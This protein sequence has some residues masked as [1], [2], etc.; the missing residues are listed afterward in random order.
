M[1]CITVIQ[2]EQETV[3]LKL[4]PL[5]KLNSRYARTVSGGGGQHGMRHYHRISGG[6]RKLG[7]LSG[8]SIAGSRPT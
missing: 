3:A 7:N 1:E 5:F 4:D 6:N 8:K 2:D